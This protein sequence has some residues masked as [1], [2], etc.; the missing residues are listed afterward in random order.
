MDYRNADGSVA[1]MCGNGIRLVARYLRDAGLES[2]AEFTVGSRAGARPVVVRPDGVVTVQ[3]GPARVL[4]RSVATV[5][6]TSHPGVVVDVG[7]P[8]LVCLLSGGLDEL[9]LSD[10]PRHDPAQFPRGVNIEF[11]VPA[12]PAGVRMRVHERGVGETRSCGTGTVAVA[13]AVLHQRGVATGRLTIDIPGGRVEV[14]IDE[15]GS[16]LTG[17]AVFVA[18]GELDSGWWDALG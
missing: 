15:A 16:T 8:H 2:S 17:P 5:S 9:D 3:M 12:G 1:E 13:A 7:N 18:S 10:P 14:T 6:G 11:A 4:N